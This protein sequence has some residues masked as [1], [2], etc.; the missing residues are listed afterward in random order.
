MN[1]AQCQDPTGHKIP[2]REAKKIYYMFGLPDGPYDPNDFASYWKCHCVELDASVYHR[3]ADNT[4][5]GRFKNNLLDDIS[6]DD[7]G[8]IVMHPPEDTFNGDLRPPE[9]V[10]GRR[11]RKG[12]TKGL[13]RYET[14]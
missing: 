6:R 7:I 2:A 9:A 3:A 12:K 11:E 14:C 8:M 10:Y 4:V 13:V 5:W 1:T